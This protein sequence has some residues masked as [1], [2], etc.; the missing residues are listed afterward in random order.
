MGAAGLEKEI[1]GHQKFSSMRRAL[2]V[3]LISAAALGSAAEEV[4][5]GKTLATGKKAVTE[6]L[7]AFS[8]PIAFAL[9]F[10]TFNP[11]EG[12][13]SDQ[14]LGEVL[15]L[16]DE[17]LAA[18]GIGAAASPEN[19]ERLEALIR[20]DFSL[21][22]EREE[23][24]DD[25]HDGLKDD[26]KHLRNL[27]EGGTEA[28]RK[29]YLRLL[30]T[31]EAI[32]KKRNVLR[33][34][35][36]FEAPTLERLAA[37]RRRP[38]NS[39]LRDEAF[40]LAVRN[41]YTLLAEQ[42]LSEIGHDPSDRS[43]RE[44]IQ[45]AHQFIGRAELNATPYHDLRTR[46]RPVGKRGAL[47]EASN[48]VDPADPHSFVPGSRLASLSH[49][50]VSQLDV[51][52]DN[53]MWHTHRKMESGTVDTWSVIENWI[54]DRVSEELLDSRKFRKDFPDFR[55]HLEDSRKV[56]FWDELKSSGTSP[57]IETVD[58]FG[59]GWR[60][61]WG[62][63]AAIEPVAHRL[64][65][66]L[67]VKFADLNYTDVGGT[68]HLL[69][70]PSALEKEMNP[71]KEMPLTRDE[72]VEAMMNSAYEFNAKPFI[73]S[74]GAITE[75]NADAILADLPR[76]ARGSFRKKQLVGRTWIRFRESM[77]EAKHDVIPRG[78][79]ITTHSEVTAGDRAIRQSMIVAFWLG[80]TDVKE[81]NYRSLWIEGFGGKSGPQY[82]EFFHDA[83]SAFGAGKRSGE[84]N[85]FNYGYGT[86]DFLWLDPGGSTVH[87]NYFC[88]YRPGHFH[89]VTFADQ[90][91]GAR[92][93]AR[94]T[95]ADIV[96]AVE[97][98]EMPDFYQTCLAWRL[99]K[100]RDLIAK[101][102][103][104]PLRDSEAGET[105][106]FT[107]P[108]TTRADRSAAANHYRIPLEEIENDLVRTGHLASGNRA[109]PTKAP[110]NDVIVK[111]GV[112]SP[113]SKAVIPGILRDFRHP[114]GFV[115]RMTRFDDDAEWKSQRFGMN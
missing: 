81:D 82:L 115:N 37:A 26:L 42:Y 23:A 24:L 89:R 99:I 35:L 76:E 41:L 7:G 36:E 111:N 48:L 52:P 83:G 15:S 70:L 59:Q 73:L 17:F 2:S 77:V 87:S 93:I 110:F 104:I 100:R 12:K 49:E 33:T 97:A 57:K 5:A 3:L 74:S 40:D 60:M 61:K 101:V 84:L 62:E 31:S 79:P 94:L 14:Q 8:E 4:T 1:S 63:E 22:K 43:L 95:K 107:I 72:L 13:R 53:P 105:P 103:D 19:L 91:S 32:R 16:F 109:G 86:G 50:E 46:K 65:L 106:E 68:S 44:I 18:Q 9:D 38:G 25:R 92:H 102:Y 58:A 112:I 21:A 88:L 11:A 80:H 34:Y 114:S 39:L 78:G 10:A 54:E 108:L 29:E 64:R 75:A 20:R 113:Y 6:P 69:I 56:L 85:R 51:S 27:L 90:L 28:N 45:I 96:R 66:L 55:Y 71:E 47:K 98:S 67:G 30:K